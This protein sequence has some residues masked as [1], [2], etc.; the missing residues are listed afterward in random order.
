MSLIPE[1]LDF[2]Q[3]I[4]KKKILCE[5]CRWISY[6]GI[7]SNLSRS[8]CKQ[9]IN[10]APTT[11]SIFP[12]E[13]LCN[14]FQCKKVSFFIF[15]LSNLILQVQCSRC[16]HN[17]SLH[18]NKDTEACIIFLKNLELVKELASDEI[19]LS[20]FPLSQAV[21]HKPL[22]WGG[23]TT[24]ETMWKARRGRIQVFGAQRRNFESL[25]V[26]YSCL[27]KINQ[28]WD[29]VW[30]ELTSHPLSTPSWLWGLEMS[31]HLFVPQFSS[32]WGELE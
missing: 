17:A 19:Q 23:E 29:S 3:V 27:P 14:S 20:W 16:Y 18:Y 15:S 10:V 26:E 8:W 6:E 2:R 32:Q 11:T 31:L 22:W 1:S 25:Q 28:R 24:R 30:T 13:F 7:W 4:L 12:I 5:Q 9:N 21:G